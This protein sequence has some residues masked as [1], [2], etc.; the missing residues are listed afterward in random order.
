MFQRIGRSVQLNPNSDGN[1]QFNAIANQLQG[2]NLSHSAG[3]ELCE[4]IVNYMIEFRISPFNERPDVSEFFDEQIYSSYDLDMMRLDSTFGDHLT[5][6]DASE[7]FLFEYAWYRQKDPIMTVL[8]FHG[9]MLLIFRPL[10]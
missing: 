7:F 8:L 9:K 10:L 5:L 2:I 3:S 1:C 6:Q 4:S